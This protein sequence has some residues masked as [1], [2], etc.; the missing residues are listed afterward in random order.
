MTRG[1]KVGVGLLILAVLIGV[2]IAI[3]DWNWFKPM[4]ERRVSAA[5]GRSFSIGN[6][7]VDLSMTP[8]VTLDRV[9]LG[10]VPWS[11]DPNMFETKRL[12]FRI[13]LLSLLRGRK[14]IPQ[15]EL[16]DPRLVLERNR[17]NQNNW[18][19]KSSGDKSDKGEGPVIGTLVVDQGRLVFQ[20]PLNRTNLNATLETRPPSDPKDEKLINIVGDG[21][22]NGAPFALKA[23][24]GSIFALRNPDK[25][26]PLRIDVRSGTSGAH[27]EGTLTDPAKLRGIDVQ[28]DMKGESLAKLDA[29]T[30]LT[31]PDTPPY[32]IAGHLTRKGD[33]WALDGFKGRVGNSDLAGNVSVD[34]GKEPK[35]F[36]AD[37]Q[38]QRL[39]FDDL[40]G[41][42][43][44]PPRTGPGEVA[45]AEQKKQAAK[46][47]AS[48]RVLPDTPYNL[49]NLNKMDADVKFRAHRFNNPKTPLDNMVAH[50]VLKGGRLSLEP[51]NFGVAGGQF[52]SDIVLD[53]RQSPIR[54]SAQIKAHSLHLNRLFPAAKVT[55]TSVGVFGGQ[56][57]LA[58]SG[59]SIA[60]ML[61]SADGELGIVMA[62]GQI[63]NLIVELMG[64]DIM[65]SV[66]YL[67]GRDRNTRIRCLAGVFDVKGGVMKTDTL[68]FDTDDTNVRGF[69]TIDLKDES[70]KLRFEPKPKDMSL[71]AVRAPID[72]Q[73]HLKKP[74]VRP[75]L[76]VVG[77]KAGAATALGVVLGP[78]AAII[79]LIE[80][81]PGQNS[82]CRALVAAASATGTPQAIRKH[83]ASRAAR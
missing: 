55:K 69:G 67:V 80:T 11:S 21:T 39:D 22:N 16:A 41:F 35:F 54:S 51:L 64:L 59:N 65:E 17:E 42:V 27:A 78:L 75:D 83:A 6:L 33:V 7:D 1:R 8:L 25:P 72:I 36:Q 60:K 34:A 43:K 40:A 79:P 37:V 61:G 9:Q 52:D 70:L 5:T 3:W 49:T 44:A 26:Y 4:V 23:E 32:H 62:S 15:I 12:A 71:L 66:K 18:T 2:L 45:S 76:G 14:I 63:S 77:A 28:L 31:L 24:A 48:G 19:F 81:G 58:G 68:V 29:I 38:S 20:D 53:A 13:E 10:N 47:K 56:A 73:G 57:K 50:L 82:D 46:L 30:G 74:H